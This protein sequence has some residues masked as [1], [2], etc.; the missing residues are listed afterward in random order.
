MAIAKCFDAIDLFLAIASTIRWLGSTQDEECRFFQILTMFLWM[1]AVFPA[2]HNRIL[3]QHDYVWLDLLISAPYAVLVPLVLNGRARVAASPSAVTI[4]I[5]RS[6]SS[7]FL[8]GALVLMGIFVG[9]SQYWVGSSMVL[10]A[11][12]GYSTL[13]IAIQQ[14]ALE[15]EESLLAAKAALEKLVDLDGLTGIPNRRAFDE[16]LLREFALTERTQRPISLLMIDVDLFKALNDIK[17][18][19]TGDQYLIQ[20][21]TALHLNLTR[22]TDFVAR[23]GGEEFCAILPATDSRGAWVAAEK[24]RKGVADLGLNHPNSHSGIVTVSIGVSTFDGS[25][26]SSPAQPLKTADRAL[27]IAES[28]GRNRCE[29]SRI[30]SS[31]IPVSF[32]LMAK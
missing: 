16:V 31:P 8:A 21:A 1:N 32:D 24:L 29:F 14:R 23:Y 20:I 19:L 10:L 22:S 6:G 17:G 5:I 4:K 3:M 15:A 25:A 28:C 9:R 12:A 11:M 18:H 30:K 27:Y 2:I 26:L 13:N 7:V